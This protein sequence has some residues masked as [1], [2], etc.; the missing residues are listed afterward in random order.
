MP[1][2]LPEFPRYDLNDRAAV[3]TGGS[4]GL[5]KWIA[6]GLARTGAEETCHSIKQMGQKA[7]PWSIDVADAH[8]VDVMITAAGREL[9]GGKLH[10]RPDLV[11]RWRTDDPL[12]ALG[13]D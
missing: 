5:G 9:G 13:R 7:V 12:I 6:L 2:A 1:E 8:A 11:C 10:N 3:V 4:R